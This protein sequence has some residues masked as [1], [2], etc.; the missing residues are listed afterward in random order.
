MDCCK[1]CT[2]IVCWVVD[3]VVGPIKDK[4]TIVS[5]DNSTSFNNCCVMNKIITTNETQWY[6]TYC[7]YCTIIVCWVIDKVVGSTEGKNNIVS[8]KTAPP[9]TP[10]ELWVKL[11]ASTN[12]NQWYVGCCKDCTT[13][14]WV[15][16]DKD[17][18]SI[19]GKNTIVSCDKRTT[20]NTF[21]VIS[22]TINEN[23]WDV[24]CCID[25]TTCTLFAELLIKLLAPLKVRTPLPVVKTAHRCWV[26]DKVIS[27]IQ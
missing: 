5:C 12:E 22:K 20:F 21:W 8:C 15:V 4:N 25:C 14:C 27:S 24:H 6:V 10:A 3:E 7:I 11:L 2:T 18:G 19:E 23:Q 1:G 17:V 26:V 9:L 16:V 13:V